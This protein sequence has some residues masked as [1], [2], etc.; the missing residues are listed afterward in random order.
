MEIG[1]E[2]KGISQADGDALIG[3][4][5]KWSESQNKG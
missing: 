1:E 3:E 2:S 4:F 5:L